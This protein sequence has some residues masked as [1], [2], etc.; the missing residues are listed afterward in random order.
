MVEKDLET[1]RPP[2]AVL[3]VD[4]Y[5]HH[6]KVGGFGRSVK[7]ALLSYCKNIAL[8]GL[9]KVG[10]RKFVWAMLRVFVG[11]T[12]DR[13]E[14]RIH[15]NLLDDFLIHLSNNGIYQKQVWIVRH[16]VYEPK[17][18]DLIYKDPRTPREM[19]GEII[20]YILEP[21]KT[22]V[23]TLDPGQGKTFIAL[24]AISILE[25]VT[26]INIKA[27]YIEKWIGDIHEAF[28]IKPG[29]LMVVKGNSNLKKLME[30]A[31]AGELEAKIIICSNMTFFNYL[32]TYE[33]Y[34]KEI[35][36]LGYPLLPEE[37]FESLGVGLRLIDEV[38]QDFHLNFRQD[39]YTHVPTTL[40][41]SGTLDSDNEFINRM[42]AVMF[43]PAERFHRHQRDIYV[44]VEALVYRIHHVDNRLNYTNKALKSYSHIK[45][46]Q[47][48][49]KNKNLLTS[50]VNMVCDIVQKRF[51]NLREHG[52]KMVIYHSTVELCGIVAGELKRRQAA[53][54]VT[55][56]VSEDDYEEMLECDIIVSTLKSLGTAIDVPGLR[57]VLL[58]D[59]LGS[60]Q[61]NLQCMGR[62]RRL[63]DWPDTTPEFLYLVC[64]DIQ[65]HKDYHY[66]KKEV[67]SGRVL[68]HEVTQLHLVL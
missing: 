12:K 38:H 39:L 20:D 3:R 50:Y 5:S 30:L 15:A 67:F 19:Q 51:V 14:F 17:S 55:R 40:S 68:R 58:T 54:E 64:D 53:L 48:M 46:E 56:Y 42:Y 9:K 63:K 8:Y 59:A 1:L 4:L 23:V 10:Q 35:K 13:E 11:V 47:S 26:F 16:P 29:E 22:K 65:K 44:S 27:M 57:T 52:Q 31:V 43:P 21:G 36:D 24:R 33:A 2:G 49:M 18:V 34:G 45:F 66:K 32:K 62:L 25:Q 60:K 37:F 28:D 6:F 41:L 61:A 7:D